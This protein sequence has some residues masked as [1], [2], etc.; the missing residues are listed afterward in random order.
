M[1][2]MYSMSSPV[3]TRRAI[4]MGAIGVMATAALAIPLVLAASHELATQSRSPLPQKAQMMDKTTIE[5]DQ[6][7]RCL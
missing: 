1:S 5:D 7:D 3:R 2:E 6:A 4:L